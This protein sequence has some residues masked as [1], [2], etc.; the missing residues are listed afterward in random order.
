[1]AP[2]VIAEPVIDPNR[3]RVPAGELVI[4]QHTTL[5]PVWSDPQEATDAVTPFTAAFAMHDALIKP[6][7]Q[8]VWTYG[9]AEHFE[10]PADFTKATFRLREGLKFHNGDPVTTED[11]KWTWENYRGANA[12]VFQGKT[13]RIEILDD[14]NIVFHFNEPFIDFLDILASFSTG[15]GWILPK[16]YY[17]QVGP[18]GF[19]ENPIGAGPYKFVSQVA[20]SEIVWEANTDYWR[21]VP[22]I[23]KITIRGTRELATRSAALKSG[24]ADM[25]Y[26]I[27]GE[28]LKEFLADPDLRIEPNNS[29]PFFMF[30]PDR[31]EADS[32]FND[33]RVREAV[34]LVLDRQFLANAETQGLAIPWANIMGPEKPGALTRSVPAQ[35]LAK[36][37]QLM[38]DA[39]YAEGFTLDWFTPFPP[40]FS[41]ALRIMD[42]LREINIESEMQKTERPVF[43]SMMRDGRDGFPG[44]QV[45]FSITLGPANAAGY[46]N[47]FATCDGPSPE[48][49]DPVIEGLWAKYNASL[50]LAE[51]DSLVKEIQKFMLDEFLFVPIYINSFAFGF[52]PDI[53]G[54]PSEYLQAAIYPFPYENIRLVDSPA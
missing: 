16:K 40:V 5:S 25:A 6:M 45:V 53:F 3:S 8:G 54:D 4:A 38:A 36:A 44:R 37:K 52:G 50:D 21:K 10:M 28:V 43:L 23:K 27:T 48:V 2:F 22:H 7:P 1:M 51:R 41:L 30:F 14:R 35:D 26:F 42:S 9:L 11:V 17:E 47:S 39:G 13:E 31:A 49:C 33:K 24:D 29:A 46:I 18:D 12:D 19:K 20:G 34:S 32:P 15:I